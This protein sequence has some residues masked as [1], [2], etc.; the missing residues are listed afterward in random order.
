MIKFNKLDGDVV[1]WIADH[2][3]DTAKSEAKYYQSLEAYGWCDDT[4]KEK[5]DELVIDI[6]RSEDEHD[7]VEMRGK[8]NRLQEIL[9]KLEQIS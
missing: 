5:I 3:L 7:V 1:E 6:D 8:I 9:N 4:I 2:I